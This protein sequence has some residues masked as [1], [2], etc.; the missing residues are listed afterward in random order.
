[1]GRLRESAA[2]G[3]RGRE[4]RELAATMSTK[5]PEEDVSKS[6][7]KE[8][9]LGRTGSLLRTGRLSGGPS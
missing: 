8:M 5:P 9:I 7:S 2:V 4:A 6:Q 1:M 3:T